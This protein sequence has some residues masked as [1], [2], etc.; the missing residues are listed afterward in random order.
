MVSARCT[1]PQYMHHGYFSKTAA[2]ARRFTF[3]SPNLISRSR[4]GN[5]GQPAQCELRNFGNVIVGEA[6]TKA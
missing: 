1:P 2:C 3:A 5:M 4:C 6:S